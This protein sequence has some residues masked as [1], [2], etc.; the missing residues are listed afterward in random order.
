[1]AVLEDWRTALERAQQL[2]Q[3]VYRAAVALLWTTAMRLGSPRRVR[4]GSGDSAPPEAADRAAPDSASQPA[5][6]LAARAGCNQSPMLSR[7][8]IKM[9]L[10]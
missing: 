9:Q 6:A 1:M 3:N 8:L 2:H 10:R 4:P 5:E 7:H